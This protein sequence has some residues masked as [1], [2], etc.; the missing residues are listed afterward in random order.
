M[1]F[2]AISITATAVS[3]VGTAGAPVITTEG[4]LTGSTIAVYR[5]N[6]RTQQVRT[7]EILSLC[8]NKHV[9]GT[10]YF[11]MMPLK[12]IPVI[13]LHEYFDYTHYLSIL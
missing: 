4:V 1:L 8:N 2:T 10:L 5:M 3:F 7:F 11:R 13:L 12:L 9:N 6:N